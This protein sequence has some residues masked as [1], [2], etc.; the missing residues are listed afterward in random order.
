ML[1]SKREELAE[2]YQQWLEDVLKR[3]GTKIVDNALAVITFLDN[4]GYLKEIKK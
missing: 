3:K 1:Y 4:N 2:Q